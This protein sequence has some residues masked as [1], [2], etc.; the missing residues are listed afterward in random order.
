MELI[1]VS[2]CGVGPEDEVGDGAQGQEGV[3]PGEAGRRVP[4]TAGSFVPASVHDWPQAVTLALLVYSLHSAAP[5]RPIVSAYLRH[6]ALLRH[7]LQH[8][9]V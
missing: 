2:N 3:A 4:L 7:A 1:E 6:L 5:L 8:F 9:E